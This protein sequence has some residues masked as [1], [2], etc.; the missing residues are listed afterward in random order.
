MRRHVLRNASLPALT[1][2]GF[3]VVSL[4]SSAVIFAWPGVGQVALQ[5]V[6]RRDLPVLLSAVFYTGVLVTSAIS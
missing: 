2:L 4:L 3:E 1:V 6:E 5:A